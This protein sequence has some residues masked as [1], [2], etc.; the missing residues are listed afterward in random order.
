MGTTA[1]GVA[2]LCW[3]NGLWVASGGGPLL[4]A[5]ALLARDSRLLLAFALYAA[6]RHL[7]PARTWPALRRAF[8]LDAT[9]YFAA[10]ELRYDGFEALPP[11]DARMLCFH[12]HGVLCC[13]WTVANAHPALDAARVTW[14]AA[15]VLLALPGI[16]DFLRW[17][18]TRGVGAA[19]LRRMLAARRNVALLP[20]GFE[21]ATVYARGAFRVYIRN[22]KARAAAWGEPRGESCNTA[23]LASARLRLVR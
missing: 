4:L 15:D 10:Q 21:E 17:C 3:F 5:Y 13:G 23:S 1:L 2:K 11:D 19:T 12:P 22:R 6:Y 7:R 16:G 9:P 18:K 14:L 20:G 8:R